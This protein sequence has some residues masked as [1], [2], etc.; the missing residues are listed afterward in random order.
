M[1]P[2]LGFVRLICEQQGATRISTEVPII[3]S[4]IQ[5]NSS[6]EGIKCNT[7][8]FVDNTKP[9]GNWS[10]WFARN[11]REALSGH[12]QYGCTEWSRLWCVEYNVEKCEVL[13]SLTIIVTETGPLDKLEHADQD[14]HLS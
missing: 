8:T 1:G 2:R 5:F 10:V 11:S 12:I 6:G 9:G 3:H 13:E 7:S 14:V 4:S